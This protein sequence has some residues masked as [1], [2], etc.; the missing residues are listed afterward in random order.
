VTRLTD[1]TVTSIAPGGVI[2]VRVKRPGSELTY[3][4]VGTVER[5]KQAGEI[6]YAWK[7]GDHH[8]TNSKYIGAVLVA[9]KHIERAEVRP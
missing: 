7:V 1:R 4:T 3:D 8:G 6:F 2:T 5:V 9:A